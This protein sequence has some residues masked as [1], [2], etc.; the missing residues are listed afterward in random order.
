MD[1][2]TFYAL[3]GMLNVEEVSLETLKKRLSTIVEFV[4]G[5]R[6]LIIEGVAVSVHIFDIN[7]L[8][9]LI[10]VK[11]MENVKCYIEIGGDLRQVVYVDYKCNGKCCSNA[12]PLP[13]TMDKLKDVFDVEY[14]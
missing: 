11:T 12:Y 10:G 8:C 4:P 3:T 1:K 14:V 7:K 6:G 13:F 9:K 2:L 5:L